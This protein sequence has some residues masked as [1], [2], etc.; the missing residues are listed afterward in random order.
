MR[1]SGVRFIGLGGVGRRAAEPICRTLLYQTKDKLPE[2]TFIDGDEY[3]PRNV[4]RQPCTD[5]D[6]TQQVNK[7]ASAAA[8]IKRVLGIE[9]GVYPNYL[10]PRNAS[11]LL[12]ENDLIIAGVDSFAVRKLIADFAERRDNIVLIS[13][14]NELTDG[15]VQVFIRRDGKN[16]TAN[17]GEYHPEIADPQD[18]RPDQHTCLREQVVHPQL[19]RTNN[20]VAAI[21][22]SIVGELLEL[23]E[24]ELPNWTV[25]EVCFDL[26]KFKAIP[27]ERESLRE[28]EEVTA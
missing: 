3:E 17:L 1:F 10:I 24:E 14:G 20:M 11:N 6:A 28:V 9:V 4:E 15:N 21:M 27:H 25:G 7:A 2:I 19:V 18:T 8:E 16:L 5:E 12:K 22:T 26:K 13:G 23:P